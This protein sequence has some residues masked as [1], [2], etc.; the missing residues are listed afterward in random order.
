MEKNKIENINLHDLVENQDNPRTIE[1]EKKCHHV[2]SR[3]R[4]NKVVDSGTCNRIPNRDMKPKNESNRQ[5]GC[6]YP[7]A[8]DFPHLQLV[9]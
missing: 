2:K 1:H 7:D 4:R 5:E 6:E 8:D 3:V 9:K